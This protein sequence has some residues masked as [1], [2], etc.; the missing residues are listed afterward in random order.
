MA[1][2][3]IAAGFK[4]L[5][6]GVINEDG[7]FIGSTTTVPPVGTTTNGG[8][9]RLAGART[10][11][12][13]IGETVV[14]PADGDDETL[15]TFEFD[16]PGLPNGVFE[17]AVRNNVFEALTQ[18]TKINTL[19]SD[20]EISMIDPADRDSQTMC[21]LGS[22]R[23]KSW[24]SGEKGSKKWENFYLPNCTI[25][26]LGISP[27][28]RSYTPYNY[29]I[30]LSKSDRLG[31]TTVNNSE[32]GTTAVPAAYI[33]SDNPLHLHRGT[34]DAATTTFDVDFPPVS[35][36]KSYVFVN[37]LQQTVTTNYTLSGV[38]F[39]FLVAP[40]SNAVIAFLYEVEEA[41]IS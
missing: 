12:I 24:K 22:R 10:M 5:R 26:P 28:Q 39:T 25:K 37:D 19:S 23:A 8:M 32:H 3:I 41:D 13:Q 4:Y 9:A 15:V 30:N 21:L 11:P 35:G 6:Y 17:M 1:R 33:D 20:A 38:Q 40:A 18:G 14:E 36:A 7:I 16:P 29:S 34:G 27:V 2:E 31:W